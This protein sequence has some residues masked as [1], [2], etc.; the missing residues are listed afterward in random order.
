MTSDAV[1][2]Q[3]VQQFPITN[4][5]KRF[6]KIKVHCPIVILVVESIFMCSSLW[7]HLGCTISWCRR[8]GNLYISNFNYHLK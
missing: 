2:I 7:L 3:L 1:G 4:G 5:V 8:V 6:S